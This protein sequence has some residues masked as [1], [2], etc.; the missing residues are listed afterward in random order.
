MRTRRQ[1]CYLFRWRVTILL[2]AAV[3]AGCPRILYL[4]YKPSTSAKGTGPVQVATFIYAGHPT[5]LMKQREVETDSGDPEAL[6][7][8]RDIS[9][10][11]TVALKRELAFAGY[12][13]ETNASRRVS[14]T[15]EQFFLDYV[16][17]SDQRFYIQVTF[18]VTRIEG[19]PFTSTCRVDRH[20]ARDWMK[21]GLLIEQGVRACIDE[22]ILSAQAAGAL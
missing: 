17:V 11:F 18:T 1:N 15:I 20:Q 19:S 14:G 8:S 3:L 4:D 12:E 6:F 16:G 9:S 21:S 7:L 2:A 5:G 22:F 10:F 13:V